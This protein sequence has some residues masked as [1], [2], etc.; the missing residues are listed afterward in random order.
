MP[1]YNPGGRVL[2]GRV[3]KI[4]LFGLVILD[5]PELRLA[6]VPCSVSGICFI[7]FSFCQIVFGFWLP[8]HEGMLAGNV[9][10]CFRCKKD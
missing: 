2:F 9:N 5:P 7:F 10:V 3:I 1:S 4:L 6:F 8:S